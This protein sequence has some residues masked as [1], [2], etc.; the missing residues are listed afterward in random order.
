MQQF[1]AMPFSFC[2]RD[3]VCNYASRTATSYWLSTPQAKPM[4]PLTSY[5]QILPYISRL[6]CARM[7]SNSDSTRGL[8]VSHCVS[9]VNR[10]SD[11]NG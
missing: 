2:D 6:V 11:V 5:S 7:T 4:M 3:G 1:S 9:F 10:I 8:G